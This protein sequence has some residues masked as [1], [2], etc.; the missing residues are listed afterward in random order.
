MTQ[1]LSAS[2]D[3][4][5]RAEWRTGWPVLLGATGA[6]STGGALLVYTASYFVKPM[7]QAL[8][9][10][11]GDIAL[12]SSLAL[13]IGAIALPM[14]GLL[15]DRF[16]KR[17]VGLTCI[18]GYGLLCLALAAI[19]PERAYYYAVM[20]AIALL[21]SGTTPV[22]FGPLV[23]GAF[24]RWRGTAVGVMGCGIAL[25]LVPLAPV[26][27]RLLNDMGWRAGYV[28]LGGAALL[29]GLPSG[30]L[31]LSR[32]P[33]AAGSKGVVHAPGLTLRQAIRTTTYWKL[34]IAIFAATLAIG[35][36]LSQMVP[37]FSD[38]G[39]SV[40]QVGGV[41]STYVVAIVIARIAVGWLLYY[42]SPPLVALA[43]MLIAAAGCALL[44]AVDAPTFVL[45]LVV[46]STIGLAL[47]AEGNIQAFFTARHFG[48]RNF[49]TIYGSLGLVV[50]VGFGAGAALFGKCYDHYQNYDL[51][52]MIATGGFI[53]SALLLGSMVWSRPLVTEPMPAT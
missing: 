48:I 26:L 18:I 4:S 5:P 7:Q 20:V 9:W 22:V 10:S 12:G 39:L 44:V 6:V 41:A 14:A 8:G 27:V 40:A 36:F 19:P 21:Y 17:L 38:K 42:L 49:A 23:V 45:C 52:L 25:L 50:S 30:L 35:G 51:A 53:L 2:A 11:R 13:W 47:G 29:V 37:M 28:A 1:P 32:A 46:I 3:L 24:E 31:A 15:A 16:G 33:A 34:A 43:I